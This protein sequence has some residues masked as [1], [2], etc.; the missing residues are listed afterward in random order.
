M[1]ACENELLSQTNHGGFKLSIVAKFQARAPVSYIIRVASPQGNE[2]NFVS[3]LDGFK[4]IG[5][6]LIA[7]HHFAGTK[8]YPTDTEKLREVLT[9]DFIKNFVKLGKSGEFR[10]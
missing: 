8:L 3:T 4:N 10:V 5:E 1:S 6:L 2:V 9:A 7:L